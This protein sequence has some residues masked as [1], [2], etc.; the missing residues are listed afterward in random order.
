MIESFQITK[1][2]L[3]ESVL[4]YHTLPKPMD[5]IWAKKWRCKCPVAICLQERGLDAEVMKDTI[6][7]RGCGVVVMP[8]EVIDYVHLADTNLSAC[9][10][11]TFELEIPS[12][13]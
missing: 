4:F 5:W 9:K 7:I 1:E 8:K 12:H 6:F 11:F 3:E 13:A 2:H 10:P